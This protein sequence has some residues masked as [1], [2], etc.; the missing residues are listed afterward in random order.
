MSHDPHDRPGAYK[1]AQ[2]IEAGF[3][4]P[5]PRGVVLALDADGEII[6]EAAPEAR[7]TRGPWLAV[8]AGALLLFGAVIGLSVLVIAVGL[9]I[10]LLQVA[11]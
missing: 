10:L 11:A 5:P 8:A 9:S 4:G 6:P 2:R 7:A 1:V 3:D